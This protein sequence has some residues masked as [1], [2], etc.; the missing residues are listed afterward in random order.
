[1]LDT[2][3]E[4]FSLFPVPCAVYVSLHTQ[5]TKMYVRVCGVGGGRGGEKQRETD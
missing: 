1:M 4:E 5:R 3:S 2:V